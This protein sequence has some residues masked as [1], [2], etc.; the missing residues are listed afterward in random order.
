MRSRARLAVTLGDPRGIGPEIVAAARARDA[1]A[2]LVIVGAEGTGVAVDEAVGGW[3]PGSPAPHAGRP[4][5]QAGGRPLEPALRGGGGRVVT[6][7]LGQR[8]PPPGG[9]GF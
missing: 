1:G 5:G 9:L 3:K 6:G 2:D 8:A 7:P 4:A